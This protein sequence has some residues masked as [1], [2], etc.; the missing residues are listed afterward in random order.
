MKIAPLNLNNA[1]QGGNFKGKTPNID[2]LIAIKKAAN[3]SLNGLEE[4]LI[5]S[6]EKKSS[7]LIQELNGQKY[8]PDDTLKK[9]LTSSLK[10]FFGMPL[11]VIDFIVRKFP[12][13][14]L[15]NA[16]FLQK[17]RES[18]QLEDEIRAL[19]GIHRNTS[20]YATEA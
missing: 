8:I 3:Y 14:K 17:Y 13:S 20:K 16:E 7:G 4:S 5:D 12:K 1:R 18:V 10:I 2:N 19:Q 11:D 9:K 6:I 15:N